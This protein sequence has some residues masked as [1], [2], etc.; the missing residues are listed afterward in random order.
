MLAACAAVRVRVIM[1]YQI[2]L[3]WQ[4][5]LDNYDTALPAS[6]NMHMGEG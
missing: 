5:P 6:L 2:S 3:L 1:G 4:K